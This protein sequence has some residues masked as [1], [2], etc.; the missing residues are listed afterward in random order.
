M[1]QAKSNVD[2]TVRFFADLLY[3]ASYRNARV[4]YSEPTGIVDIFPETLITLYSAGLRG[5]LGFGALRGRLRSDCLR[6]VGEP[7]SNEERATPNK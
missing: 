7:I 3:G 2:I 5:H 6:M 4:Q 1:V